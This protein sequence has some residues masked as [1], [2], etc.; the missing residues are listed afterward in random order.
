MS[1]VIKGKFPA[2][3]SLDVS[4]N[5]LDGE[6]MRQLVKGDWQHLW[7]S[8]DRFRLTPTASRKA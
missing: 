4:S 6:A 2:L 8:H 3:V 7:L 1:E 5:K